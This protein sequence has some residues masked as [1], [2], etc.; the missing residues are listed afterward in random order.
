MT[1]WF[2]V[3]LDL[4][5]CLVCLLSEAE[6]L[7]GNSRAFAGGRIYEQAAVDER[8]HRTRRREPRLGRSHDRNR[9]KLG[10]QEGGRLRHDQVGLKQVR[11]GNA[12]YGSRSCVRVDSRV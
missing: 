1:P 2:F 6:Q 10:V 8:L 11:S 12:F 9:S 5:A 3:R 4:S 7:S